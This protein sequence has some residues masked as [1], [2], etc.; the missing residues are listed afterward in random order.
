MLRR[1]VG[2]VIFSIE[3]SRVKALDKFRSSP[4]VAA[5]ASGAVAQCGTSDA[6]PVLS[7]SAVQSLFNDAIYPLSSR[8][9]HVSTLW[10]AIHAK[11]LKITKDN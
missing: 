6:A 7:E 4:G 3:R 5:E 10:R 9:R 11:G 2:P 8:D 1:I